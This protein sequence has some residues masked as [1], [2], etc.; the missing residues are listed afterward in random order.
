LQR[1]DSR[2]MF[3]K[4]ILK[5]RV[6]PKGPVGNPICSMTTNILSINKRK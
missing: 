3:R 1:R 4:I 2:K 5:N 6:L